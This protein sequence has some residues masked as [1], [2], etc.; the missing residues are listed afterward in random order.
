MKVR[1]LKGDCYLGTADTMEEWKLWISSSALL[2][3]RSLTLSRPNS[4]ANSFSKED[5]KTEAQRSEAKHTHES[6]KSR[7]KNSLEIKFGNGHIC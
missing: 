3:F 1:K 6:N 2:L 5:A 7:R 4:H